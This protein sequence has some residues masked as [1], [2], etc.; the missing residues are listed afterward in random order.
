VILGKKF[1]ANLVVVRPQPRLLGGRSRPSGAQSNKPP[2][3]EDNSEPERPMRWS[4]VAEFQ[5]KSPG[6]AT[7]SMMLIFPQK[8]LAGQ[9]TE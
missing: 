1:D 7:I 2:K 6:R 8:M 5:V 4:R 3:K 9:G